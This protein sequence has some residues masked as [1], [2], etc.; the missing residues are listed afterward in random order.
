MPSFV[1][2]D[3]AFG[4]L[5]V[6]GWL[7][8]RQ[9]GGRH[10]AGTSDDQVVRADLGSALRA[11]GVAVLLL[12]GLLTMAQMPGGFTLAIWSVLALG[13]GAVGALM[14]GFRWWVER[15]DLRGST[16][17]S[18]QIR[19]ESETWEFALIGAVTGLTS[20]YVLGLVL[21]I[22]QPVH[23]GI[24]LL[25]G[26]VGYA[27]G[28]IIWTPR[29]RIHRVETSIPSEATTAA[30]RRPPYRSRRRQRARPTA[31]HA[32]AGRARS[33]DQTP[34]EAGGERH[35]GEDDRRD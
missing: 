34:D 17:K 25:G 31:V 24:S 15:W 6:V 7:W 32:L 28:L 11:W 3:L 26:T 33:G 30:V 8:L 27:L 10:P 1:I 35:D 23:L 29:A 13:L 18:D 16:P 5:A 4:S 22:M 19:V 21:N 9:V 12:L 2:A 20:T 14:A